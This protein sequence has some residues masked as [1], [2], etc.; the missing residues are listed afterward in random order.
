ME[1][2]ENSVAVMPLVKVFLSCQDPN[3]A[4]EL[5][6]ECNKQKG[7]MSGG[8][9]VPTKLTQDGKWGFANPVEFNLKND[10][11]LMTLSCE[12]T[13]LKKSIDLD[14]ALQHY[15]DEKNHTSQQWSATID[16]AANYADDAL[17]LVLLLTICPGAISK[18]KNFKF[19]SLTLGVPSFFSETVKINLNNVSVQ[20]YVA[21]RN[22]Q[23]DEHSFSYK[24]STQ[25]Q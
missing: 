9:Y 18:T 25:E 13:T 10:K 2:D 23:I 24:N 17:L 12:G 19:P 6:L 20:Y 16:R 1:Q 22:A 4:D 21:D 14:L 15:R 8:I 7:L 5:S 11:N 3:Y